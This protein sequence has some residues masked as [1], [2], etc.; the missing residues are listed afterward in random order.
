M[1]MNKAEN[2]FK[3]L[4][5]KTLANKK[6]TFKSKFIFKRL[7]VRNKD[8]KDI[9][10]QWI[11][12]M[13]ERDEIGL[14][15]TGK[16][17]N[18]EIV[19][20]TEDYFV[21][22]I[23]NLLI[24][25]DFLLDENS[26]YSFFKEISKTE[27]PNSDMLVKKIEKFTHP[28]VKFVKG[29]RDVPIMFN[30]YKVFVPERLINISENMMEKIS[31]SPEKFS[32]SKRVKK[33][34]FKDTKN[35][36]GDYSV[37]EMILT[38][39]SS[40][41]SETGK[42][43]LTKGEILNSR[44]YKVFFNAPK[45]SEFSRLIKKIYPFNPFIGEDFVSFYPE[46]WLDI[47]LIKKQINNEAPS[48]FFRRNCEFLTKEETSALISILNLEQN[49]A[50]SVQVESNQ[51]ET[52]QETF[53]TTE[54]EPI[55]PEKENNQKNTEKLKTNRKQRGKEKSKVENQKK[56]ITQKSEPL[57]FLNEIIHKESKNENVSNTES[58][59]EIVNEFDKT[60]RHYLLRILD[61][62]KVDSGY[63]SHSQKDVKF[64]RFLE[65]ISSSNL[66]STTVTNENYMIKRNLPVG[67]IQYKKL[68]EKLEDIIL[69]SKNTSSAQ[70]D[71]NKKSN[72]QSSFS[73]FETP[74]PS[75]ANQKKDDLLLDDLLVNDSDEDMKK[76]D[77]S[78]I[79]HT[80]DEEQESLIIANE[81]EELDEETDD[82]K[83]N[84]VDHES[85]FEISNDEETRDVHKE[86]METHEDLNR[87]F[88]QG[89]EDEQIGVRE[90]E[91][92]EEEEKE[93]EKVEATIQEEE[94]KEGLNGKII[95]VLTDDQEKWLMIKMLSEEI[96]FELRDGLAYKPEIAVFDEGFLH[97]EPIAR[98]TGAFIMQIDEFMNRLGLRDKN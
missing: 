13:I 11:D 42:L 83:M 20:M 5:E 53:Q 28:L 88:Q 61:S 12:T 46:N 82:L 78:E 21:A 9:L 7:K 70:T 4:L 10:L 69:T 8:L 91:E 32:E 54:T 39:I 44:G 57:T 79:D 35:Q 97:L 73:Q 3:D 6:G 66:F 43:V 67:D 87:E 52:N 37:Y 48:V 96:G 27:N 62:T 14:V 75:S 72:A 84:E 60:E 55:I 38:A 2:L 19:Y 63:Y 90:K 26:I 80:H 49:S 76:D 56:K 50:E 34:M 81:K 41:L 65:R 47:K 94:I 74:P 68:R 29:S 93:E 95:S 33:L 24:N 71:S 1:K 40:V 86:I 89:K 22:I 64:R 31:T 25:F 59:I 18:G 77:Q 30:L 92:E 15:N 98:N 51:K 17:K 85:F 58:L 36:Q 23:K 16:D 45:F